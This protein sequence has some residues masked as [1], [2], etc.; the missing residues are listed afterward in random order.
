MM[1]FIALT[2]Q[3]FAGYIAVIGGA[4]LSAFL[5]YRK[6]NDDAKRDLELSQ[7]RLDADNASRALSIRGDLPSDPSAVG[8]RLRRWER[9]G[10]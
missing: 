7:R 3:R 4:L 6:G 1:A 2:W 10:S 5:L 9:T 8:G